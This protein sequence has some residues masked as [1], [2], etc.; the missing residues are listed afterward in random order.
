ME[1][2]FMKIAIEEAQ[3]A[4]AEGEMPVGAVV[5]KDGQ[6]IAT[7]HNIRNMQHDP[8][9]HAEIVAIRKACRILSDWRLSDCDIYVTLEP[10]AMCCGAIAQAKIRRLYFGAYDPKG[11]FAVSNACLAEH[12][13]M[14]HKME[15]YCGIMEDECSEVLHCFF[16]K[17]RKLEDKL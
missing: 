2:K 10:C 12:P 3:A 17:M 13:G 14:M 11:G 8:T 7:G 6:V 16:N 9:L 5:V 15:C 1:N 4:I